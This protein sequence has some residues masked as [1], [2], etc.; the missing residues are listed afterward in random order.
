LEF[1]ANPEARRN[2]TFLS[3]MDDGEL[4]AAD[5]F[6]RGED[7]E[8]NGRGIDLASCYD[9]DGLYALHLCAINNE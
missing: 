6:L 5:T 7:G 2:A 9:K 1:E 8:G 4:E 3:L